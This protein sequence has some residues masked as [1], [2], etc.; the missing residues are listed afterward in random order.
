[1]A[2]G[3]TGQ[4][5]RRH[6]QDTHIACAG[7]PARHRPPLA[8][9]PAIAAFRGI[10]YAHYRRQGRIFP[11]RLTTDPYRILVSEFMLQQT[12]TERVLRKYPPFIAAF[13][14]LA[15]LAESPL[16]D[17]LMLWQGLGYNRRALALQACARRVRDVHGGK[18]PAT[19]AA[20]IALPGVGPSTAGAVLAFAYQIP[21]AFIETNI[22]R[23]FLHHFFPARQ[24]VKD[25]EILPLVEAS[26]DRDNPRGWY[27]ALMDYGV[28]LKRDTPNPNRRSAHYQRQSP[29]EGSRRQV[30]GRVLAALVDGP[31]TPARL[32]DMLKQEEPSIRAALLALETEGFLRRNGDTYSIL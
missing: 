10:V 14:D 18:V 26:L 31:A 2:T 29:F 25:A 20:L 5:T 21:T 22:R 6:G 12:Q 9:R 30:R 16:P 17:V 7:G 23:V 3:K 27:Y 15:S 13:P 1:M 4:D 28:Q 19:A 8:D 24:A 11:W 32:A